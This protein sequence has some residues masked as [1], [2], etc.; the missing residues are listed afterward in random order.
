MNEERKIGK[1]CRW[2]G[3]IYPHGGKKKP[4]SEMPT[5]CRPGTLRR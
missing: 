3:K 1:I 5:Y 2:P 4:E